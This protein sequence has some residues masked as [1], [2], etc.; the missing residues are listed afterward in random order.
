MRNERAE[1][2]DR[3]EKEFN[4]ELML[5]LWETLRNLSEEEA[6]ELEARLLNELNERGSE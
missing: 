6:L 2:L 5:D 3:T 4:T 1:L